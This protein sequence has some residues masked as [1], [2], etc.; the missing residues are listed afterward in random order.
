MAVKEINM[1]LKSARGSKLALRSKPAA[2]AR[3][4]LQAWNAV[5]SGWRRDVL[6]D[7]MIHPSDVG[8]STSGT[9]EQFNEADKPLE[10]LNN[11]ASRGVGLQLI[12]IR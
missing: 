1:W 7:G 6:S 2:Q 12:F 9:P 5:P 3:L 8:R 10:G 4:E 11:L